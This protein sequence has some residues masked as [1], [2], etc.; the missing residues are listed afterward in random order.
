MPPRKITDRLIVIVS[1]AVFAV[2]AQQTGT[3]QNLHRYTLRFSDTESFPYSTTLFG[4]EKEGS[5]FQADFPFAQLKFAP[6]RSVFILPAVTMLPLL[7]PKQ[8][9]VFLRQLNRPGSDFT[10]TSRPCFMIRVSSSR[11]HAGCSAHKP[12]PAFRCPVQKQLWEPVPDS[13]SGS[14]RRSQSPQKSTEYSE[15]PP[16]GAPPRPL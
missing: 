13:D 16:W 15:H 3:D 4:I 14:A 12:P 6:W 9:I 2:F 11:V 5:A 1:A 10:F 7:M 8:R